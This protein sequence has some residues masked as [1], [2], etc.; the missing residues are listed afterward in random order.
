MLKYK[1][2]LIFK[3]KNFY[4]IKISKRFRAWFS[5]LK[6][7]PW[8]QEVQIQ[9]VGFGPKYCDKSSTESEIAPEYCWVWPK[10]QEKR[11]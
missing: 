1:N 7:I 5:G 9:C 3:M 2:N 11:S 4:N 8:M 10:D 6:H